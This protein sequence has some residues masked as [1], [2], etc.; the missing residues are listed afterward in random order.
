MPRK[1][2]KNCPSADFSPPPPRPR[3]QDKVYLASRRSG[4]DIVFTVV[5]GSKR[6]RSDVVFKTASSARARR[7]LKRT[8][9]NRYMRATADLCQRGDIL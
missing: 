5:D 2:P 4:R 8:L 1:K 9:L 7:R 6:V 3:R